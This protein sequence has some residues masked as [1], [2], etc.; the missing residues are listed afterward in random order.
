MRSPPSTN[1]L[2]DDVTVSKKEEEGRGE[3][4]EESQGH[5]LQCSF[6]LLSNQL[7]KQFTL[8]PKEMHTEHMNYGCLYVSGVSITEDAT[9]T[10]M[11][12]WNMVGKVRAN[13]C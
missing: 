12:I 13:G 3:E 9:Q 1:P 2:K 10:E 11:S 8:A 7:C 5:N 6:F 4:T